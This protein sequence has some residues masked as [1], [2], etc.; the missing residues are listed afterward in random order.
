MGF[1]IEDSDACCLF[2]CS[3]SLSPP[4]PVHSPACPALL[5]SITNYYVPFSITTV[6]SA[7]S[8]RSMRNEQGN[9][10]IYKTHSF[11]QRPRSK[12]KTQRYC[13]LKRQPI[14]AISR[15]PSP[16][17]VLWPLHF[18]AL[19]IF[20]SHGKSSPTGQPAEMDVHFHGCLKQSAQLALLVGRTA[21]W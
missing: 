18:E 9:K 1:P 14:N 21:Q 3:R 5:S 19:V 12:I 15:Q 4:P 13:K 6:Y 16:D 10:S 8:N 7:R 2:A 17:P 11:K 20:R